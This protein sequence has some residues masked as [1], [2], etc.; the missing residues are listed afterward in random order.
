MEASSPSFI[1]A[2]IEAKVAMN[3]ERDKLVVDQLRAIKRLG[4]PDTP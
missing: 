4:N 1:D 2:L 3:R